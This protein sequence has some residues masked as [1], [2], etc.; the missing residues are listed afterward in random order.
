MIVNE[1][2]ELGIDGTEWMTV[3]A[4]RWMLRNISRGSFS[5]PSGN[6]DRRAPVKLHQN[7]SQTDTSNVTGVF[8]RSTSRSP[9]G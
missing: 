7:S 8:C 1:F 6:S 2:G 4:S 3:T 5:A 9:I